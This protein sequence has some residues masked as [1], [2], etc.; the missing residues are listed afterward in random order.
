MLIHGTNPCD[1]DKDWKNLQLVWFG[2]VW[3]CLRQH[4]FWSFCENFNMIQLVSSVLEKIKSWFG[5]VWDH[6]HVKVLWKFHQDLI[7]SG[8]FREDLVLVWFV[9]ETISINVSLTAPY[10]FFHGILNFSNNTKDIILFDI[11]CF[12]FW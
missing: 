2:M 11:I 10:Y 7:C 9:F 5:L 1:Y 3:A 8:W 12:R 4:P 6:A